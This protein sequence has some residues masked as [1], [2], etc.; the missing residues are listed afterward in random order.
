MLGEMGESG[1]KPFGRA[2]C[3]GIALVACTSHDGSLAT[4]YERAVTNVECDNAMS[5][6]PPPEVMVMGSARWG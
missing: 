6:L 2:K 4:T 3:S 5:V 1:V